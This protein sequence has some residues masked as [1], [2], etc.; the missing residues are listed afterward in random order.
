[1][2]HHYLF[3]LGALILLQSPR[4]GLSLLQR[5]ARYEPQ[6]PSKQSAATDQVVGFL[7]SMIDAQVTAYNDAVDKWAKQKG[8]MEKVIQKSMDAE[9]KQAASEQKANMKEAHDKKLKSIAGMIAGIDSALLTLRPEKSWKKDH[10]KEAKDV[11]AIYEAFPELKPA[12]SKD[13]AL[14]STKKAVVSKQRALS[15]AKE[16][17]EMAK[18]ESKY[19]G[20]KLPSGL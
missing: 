16:V 5:S 9:A 6:S 10:E 11:E 7:L 8:D 4:G 2:Q 12:E 17:L 1:M 18:L 14:L 3:C 13:A 19:W 20:I 15:D